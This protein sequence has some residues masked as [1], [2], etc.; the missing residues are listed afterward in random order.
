MLPHILLAI[1][2]AIYTAFAF[3]EQEDFLRMSEE[4]TTPFQKALL[5]WKL[6]CQ[7]ECL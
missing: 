7:Q 2:S 3:Q 6:E 5:D 4:Q 1:P